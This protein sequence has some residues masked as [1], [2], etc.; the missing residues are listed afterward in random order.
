MFPR[1]GDDLRGVQIGGGAVAMQGMCGIGAARMQGRG[2]ILRINGNSPHTHFGG[3]AGDADCDLPA[4]G[5]Q[6]GTWDLTHAATIFRPVPL[7][8]PFFTHVPPRARRV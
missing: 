7:C 4:V 2:V 6:Q 5:D 1:G 3:G 8:F